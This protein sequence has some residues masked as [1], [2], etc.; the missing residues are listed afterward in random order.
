[1]G[2]LRGDKMRNSAGKIVEPVVLA[3]KYSEDALRYYLMSDMAT[4][5]DADFLEERLIERY[6]ADLANSLGNLLNRTLNMAEKYRTGLLRTD[7]QYKTQFDMFMRSEQLPTDAKGLLE[8]SDYLPLL[9]HAAAVVNAVGGFQQAMSEFLVH[10]AL[11]TSIGAAERCNI[12]VERTSPW[13][14]AKQKEKAQQLDAV[15][16]HLAESL[17]IIAILISPVMPKA[18][19]G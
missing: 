9:D 2:K 17:R 10:S 8:K 14:L 7:A 4:G 6:N 15:L 3:D 19:H 12:L 5:Q 16:Y 11:N 1:W 13:K 18:A